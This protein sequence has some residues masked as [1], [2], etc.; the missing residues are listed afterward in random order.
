ML[1]CIYSRPEQ[2]NQIPALEKGQLHFREKFQSLRSAISPLDGA[3]PQLYRLYSSF[4][5]PKLQKVCSWGSLNEL[6]NEEHRRSIEEDPSGSPGHVVVH[7]YT[8]ASIFIFSTC[9]HFWISLTSWTYPSN[10]YC[11]PFCLLPSFFIV[12]KLD[13]ISSGSAVGSSVGS[14]ATYLWQLDGLAAYRFDCILDWHWLSFLDDSRYFLE[15]EFIHWVGFWF[16]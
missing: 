5:L 3:K 6:M 4:C 7:F 16:F 9:F 1:P 11:R 14:M 10:T 15:N 8:L 2:T 12:Q 13:H